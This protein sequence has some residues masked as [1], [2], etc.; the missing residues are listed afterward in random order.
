MEHPPTRTFADYLTLL[1]RR[2]WVVLAMLVLAPAVAVGFSLSQPKLFLSSADIL[3][4]DAATGAQ[5]PLA[6][7]PTLVMQTETEIATSP[8]LARRV[9]AATGVTTRSAGQLVSE[10]SFGS[11]GNAAVLRVSIR[12]R[13]PRLATE[14]ANAYANQYIRYRHE[15]DTSFLTTT[16]RELEA[17]MTALRR[18]GQQKSATYTT[19]ANEAQNLLDSSALQ[20]VSAVVLRPAAA[21]A[22]IQPNPTRYGILGLGVGLVLGFALVLLWDAVDPRVRTADDIGELLGQPLLGRLTAPPGA[23][24]TSRGS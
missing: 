24:A 6:S 13:D 22:Q 3:L 12:D 1:K 10:A 21:A 11:V 14:L 17:R 15:L 23:C 20:T 5:S 16:R 19:L 9:L 8:V 4:T 18:A 2:K 7:D